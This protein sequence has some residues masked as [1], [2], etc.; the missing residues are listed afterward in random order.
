MNTNIGSVSSGTMRA[1]DLIPTF[2]SVLEG[3]PEL[4]PEHKQLCEEIKQRMG[5]EGYFESDGCSYDLNEDLFDALQH[6]APQYFYFGAHPGD[7]AD[8]GFWLLEDFL[9][10]FEGWKGPDAPPEDYEGEWLHIS[11]HGN[12]ELYVREQKPV[13]TSVWAIV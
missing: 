2:I 13:D 7:G 12:M 6:Y 8:Y 1:E 9:T 4:I 5:E 11:D 3:Q 10:E